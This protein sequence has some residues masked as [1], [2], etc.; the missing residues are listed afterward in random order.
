MIQELTD[1]VIVITDNYLDGE[2]IPYFNEP[3]GVYRG[4]DDEEDEMEMARR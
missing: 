1:A 2:G 3:D 4:K